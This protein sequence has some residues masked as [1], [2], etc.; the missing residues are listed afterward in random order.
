G[1]IGY[2][3]PEVAQTGPTVASDLY[4]VARTLAVLVFEFRGFQDPRRYRDTLP[5]ASEVEVFARYPALYR[6]LAKGTREDPGRR[7]QSAG[8]MEEQLTGVLRQV[9]GI[10]GGESSPAPSRLFTPEWAVDTE[11]PSWRCL[12]IPAVDRD[13]PA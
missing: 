8:E 9:I 4:T 1:T 7:F 3:A 10:D 6:F 5:S 2:Q 11:H 12:P 13:D